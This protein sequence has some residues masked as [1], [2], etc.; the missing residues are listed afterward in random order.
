MSQTLRP[1]ANFHCN[2]GENPYYRPE[3]ASVWW[4]DIPPGK[5]FRYDTATGVATTVVDGPGPIGGFTLQRNAD[6]LL[7][8]GKDIATLSPSGEVKPLLPF[9]IEGADR[10]NDVQADPE[11]RV[12]AGTFNGRQDGAGLYRIERDGRTVPLFKGTGCSNGMGFTPDGTHLYWTDSTAN[13]IFRFRYRR[14]TGDLTD[15]DLFYAAEKGEGTCDGMT[16]DEN[17]DVWSARW[18][19]GTITRHGTDGRVKEHVVMPVKTVSSCF[20]GGP[21]SKTL[22]VTTADGKAGSDTADGT[23]YAVD[24]GVR[25]LPEPRSAILI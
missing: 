10:F 24:V 22:Y 8:R 7:F 20:F 19:G 23:L 18:G 21:E 12:F 6:W 2:T 11:G 9:T 16:V 14:A 1:L 25:G 15:R 4:V 3:D 17:G 5:M 13:Q